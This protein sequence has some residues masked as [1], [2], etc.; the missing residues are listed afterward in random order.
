MTFNLLAGILNQESV[1]LIIPGEDFQTSFNV[2]FPNSLLFFSITPSE[3]FPTEI[4]IIES[5]L[6][7]FIVPGEDISSKL[8]Y[9]NILYSSPAP[10]PSEDFSL[11]LESPDSF[12]YRQ[13]PIQSEDISLKLIYPNIIYPSPA[14]IPSESL[15]DS[16]YEPNTLLIS[17]IIEGEEIQQSFIIVDVTPI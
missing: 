17:S 4:N 13:T 11:I 6:S 12:T 10:I 15:I 14:L 9:P 5:V 1:T 7:L 8:A 16:F 2:E 3:D